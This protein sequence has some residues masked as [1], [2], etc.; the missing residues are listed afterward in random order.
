VGLKTANDFR[1]ASVKRPETGTNR[2]A[3]PFTASMMKNTGLVR[4]SS[5][6]PAEAYGNQF[7]ESRRSKASISTKRMTQSIRETSRLMSSND[8]ERPVK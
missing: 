8:K 1:A 7:L 2:N 3:R 5:R 6:K 4:N